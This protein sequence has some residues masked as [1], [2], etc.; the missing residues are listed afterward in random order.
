MRQEEEKGAVETPGNRVDP[1]PLPAKEGLK[2]LEIDLVHKKINCTI[3]DRTVSFAI[4]RFIAK[5]LHAMD[6]VKDNSLNS[7]QFMA[8]Y[9]ALA[10]RKVVDAR[11]FYRRAKSIFKATF[12]KKLKRLICLDQEGRASK[13]ARKK[14]WILH[15]LPGMERG[16]NCIVKS[17]E[18]VSFLYPVEFSSVR[19]SFLHRIEEDILAGRYDK[20]KEQARVLFYWQQND[21]EHLSTEALYKILLY[22]TI[23]TISTTTGA[24]IGKDIEA[25]KKEF[26]RVLDTHAIAIDQKGIIGLAI[27]ELR[28]L[29]GRKS[30]E[31]GT[32]TIR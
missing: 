27:N 32:R 25:F 19:T 30:P 5:C 8:A 22:Y 2:D 11:D 26:F 15:F 3:G 31:G 6:T 18:H 14:D 7:H 20:V 13:C 12:P 23:A 21:Y 1:L 4:S 9:N 16:E 28:S 17:F 24:D 10:A 29:R